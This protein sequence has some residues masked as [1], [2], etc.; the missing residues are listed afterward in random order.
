M[1]HNTYWN[2]NEVLH[3]GVSSLWNEMDFL[4]LIQTEEY[5]EPEK[6]GV[7]YRILDYNIKA[8]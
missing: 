4:L 8:T 7:S 5:P 1:V 2:A 6:R 3:H